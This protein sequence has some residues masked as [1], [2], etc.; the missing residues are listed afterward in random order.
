[1]DLV[2]FM[3][4]V[5]LSSRLTKQCIDSEG[6]CLEEKPG[7]DETQDKD[8]IPSKTSA[9][10]E[11]SDIESQIRGELADLHA[12]RKQRSRIQ[13]LDTD[14]ECLCFIQC[15]PP[16]SA[17][18]TVD[19][20]LQEVLKTGESR[21]R[22][23][24]RLAPVDKLCRAE[25]DAIRS[26]ATEVLSNFFSSDQPRTYRIEPRIRSHT[27][28]SRDILIS[29][30]ASCVPDNGGHRANLTQPDVVILVE[31]LKN[32]CGVGVIENYEQ[33]GKF[34]VQ[35][36]AQRGGQNV[37]SSRVAAARGGD[38]ANEET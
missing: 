20:I 2:D 37:S 22:Y 34:N 4:E 9:N 33:M 18:A 6:K 28:L 12:P 23:I 19:Q 17:R 36:V 24:Q 10:V 32:V 35:T 25:Q 21:S 31:V 30:I 11:Q 14:T 38:I 27:S 29:L 8:S 1:M 3:D 5:R 7:T 26:T 16:V 15:S 13:Y